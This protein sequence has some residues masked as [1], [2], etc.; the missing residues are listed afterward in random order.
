MGM[1]IVRSASLDLQTGSVCRCLEKWHRSGPGSV[2]SSASKT[3]LHSFSSSLLSHPLDL[4]SAKPGIELIIHICTLN[5]SCRHML[6]HRKG[7]HV[8]T[9][10]V[11]AFEFCSSWGIELDLVPVETLILP[12]MRSHMTGLWE[13]FLVSI[14]TV[15]SESLEEHWE[16]CFDA[17]R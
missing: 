8:V 16:D 9:F 11:Y 7:G 10:K 2:P 5:M 4:Q 17:N 13:P 6:L 12:Y 1:S 3:A 15:S 14:I